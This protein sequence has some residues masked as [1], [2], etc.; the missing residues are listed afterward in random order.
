M[1]H[2]NHDKKGEKMWFLEIVHLNGTNT[3][4]CKEEMHFI[5]LGGEQYV[6]WG[7]MPILYWYTVYIILSFTYLLF[8]IVSHIVHI[9]CL[10]NAFRKTS[11][12]PIKTFNFSFGNDF[13]GLVF[14]FYI[15]LV[16]LNMGSFF[17]ICL[18]LY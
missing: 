3:C 18:L 13:L 2:I 8:V 14:F 6:L 11:M 5:C 12:E 4:L 7:S 15:R 17:V 10:L 9:T 1:P 16:Y